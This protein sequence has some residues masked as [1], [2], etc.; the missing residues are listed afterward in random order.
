MVS[1]MR[2]GPLVAGSIDVRK[3]CGHRIADIGSAR[4]TLD[5]R[6]CFPRPVFC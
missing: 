5:L 4:I 3:V 2:D 6:D 1:L